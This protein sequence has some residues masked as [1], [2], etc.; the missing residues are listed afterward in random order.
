MRKQ[1]YFKELP[2]F[3]QNKIL[4]AYGANTAEEIGLDKEPYA[5][6]DEKDGYV[7]AIGMLKTAI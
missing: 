3:I 6:I 5:V 4:D 2:K 7:E 1:V